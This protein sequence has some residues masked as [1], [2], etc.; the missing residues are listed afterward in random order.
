LQSDRAIDVGC[1]FFL[2]SRDHGSSAVAFSEC[3]LLPVG[4]VKTGI[5]ESIQEK[6]KEKEKGWK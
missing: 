3:I 4:V 5:H 6:G 1:E 2:L